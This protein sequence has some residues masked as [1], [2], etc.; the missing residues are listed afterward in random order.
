MNSELEL[1]EWQIR[2]KCIK[3]YQVSN[4]VKRLDSSQIHC[5]QCLVTE[6]LVVAPSVAPDQT[7]GALIPIVSIILTLATTLLTHGMHEVCETSSAAVSALLP[8][9]TVGHAVATATQVAGF[10]A[11][12]AHVL[13]ALLALAPIAPGLAAAVLVLTVTTVIT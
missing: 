12:L 2:W 7:I 3:R 8:P 11:V 6:V 13:P 5:V 9:G 4:K 1:R 10:M